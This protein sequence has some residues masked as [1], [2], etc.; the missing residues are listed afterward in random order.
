VA[1]A[2]P[3]PSLPHIA[4]DAAEDAAESDGEILVMSPASA[5]NA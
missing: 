3:C 4:Q 2:Q 1:L 5:K